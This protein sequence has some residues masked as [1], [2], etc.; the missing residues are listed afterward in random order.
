MIG[1]EYSKEK[2]TEYKERLKELEIF[3]KEIN[4]PESYENKYISKEYEIKVLDALQPF[5]S[6]YRKY[7]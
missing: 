3:V 7:I 6:E 5:V 2:L 1:K 4:I